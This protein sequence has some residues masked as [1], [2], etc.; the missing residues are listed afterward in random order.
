MKFHCASAIPKTNESNPTLRDYRGDRRGDD[1]VRAHVFVIG[2]FFFFIII[3]ARLVHAFRYNLW[4]ALSIF[5]D[6]CLVLFVQRD[7]AR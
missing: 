5:F 7:L 4:P 3:I 2:G 6:L 1:L